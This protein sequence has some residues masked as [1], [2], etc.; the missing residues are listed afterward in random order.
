MLFDQYYNYVYAISYR[1]L[2]H[3]QDAQDV[4][5][6]VFRRVFDNISKVQNTADNGLKRWI[7]TI[8]INEALRFLRQKQPLEYIADHDL[9]DMAVEPTDS[10]TSASLKSVK[11]AVNEMPTGYRTIF[12]LNVVEG[13]SHSEIAEHLGISRNTSKSQ[14]LKARRYLQN[15]LGKNESRQLRG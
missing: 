5:S 12:L 4:T 14:M 6:I 15:K 1:Y 10:T 8:A 3:H 13:L 11:A 2:Q 9:V 7:Q